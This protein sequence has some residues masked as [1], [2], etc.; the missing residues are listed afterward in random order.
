MGLTQPLVYVDSCI[1]IYLVEEHHLS[2]RGTSVIQSA[3]RSAIAANT[4]CSPGLHGFV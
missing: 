3:N 4:R 1:I 2:G